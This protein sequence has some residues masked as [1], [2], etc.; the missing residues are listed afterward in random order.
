MHTSGH[1]LLNA[2]ICMWQ[3]PII[4][5]PLGRLHCLVNIIIMNLR[6]FVLTIS[7]SDYL[8]A[9]ILRWP[10]QGHHGPFLL[11]TDISFIL[12]WGRHFQATSGLHYHIEYWNM[13]PHKNVFQLIFS[14]GLNFT[15]IM[16]IWY[17]FN[18]FSRMFVFMY[19]FMFKNSMNDQMTHA[20]KRR[21]S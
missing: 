1:V 10:I 18:T 21:R 14:F 9:V 17:F 5:G 15:D 16:F 8:S 7:R 3:W 13:C 4:L 11:M 6:M 20:F 19:W 2:V 12:N